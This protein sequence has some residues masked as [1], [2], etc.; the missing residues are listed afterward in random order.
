MQ[1]SHGCRLARTFVGSETAP[2]VDVLAVL[3]GEGLFKFETEYF[4]RVVANK[5][6]SSFFVLANLALI[7][8]AL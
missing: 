5:T 1:S 8:M 7:K 3:T 2:V 4:G 6:D